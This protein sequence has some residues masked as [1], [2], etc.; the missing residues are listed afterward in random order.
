M[1]GGASFW[2]RI[3]TAAIFIFLLSGIAY[4]Q[5]QDE[6]LAEQ[7]SPILILTKNPTQ[8]DR[9][10]IFPEPVAIM[11]AESVSNLWFHFK[12]DSGDRQGTALDFSYQDLK[13]KPATPGSPQPL[14]AL[15]NAYQSQYPDIDFSQN[16]CFVK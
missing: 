16:K 1:S 2:T 12:D 3:G 7:F 8:P 6:L 15:I 5:T 4:S 9:E 14:T 13:I 11:G 10:A